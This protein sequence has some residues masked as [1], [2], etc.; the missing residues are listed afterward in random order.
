MGDRGI[1]HVKR[2]KVTAAGEWFSKYLIFDLWAS[3]VCFL[4]SFAH[5]PLSVLKRPALWARRRRPKGNSCQRRGSKKNMKSW[6]TL[7]KN[8]PFLFS[9][10]PAE[11]QQVKWAQ[12]KPCSW[13]PLTLGEFSTTLNQA[14][15]RCY[16]MPKPS[17]PR[18]QVATLSLCSVWSPRYS[19]GMGWSADH[20]ADGGRRERQHSH[21]LG[22]C[23]FL[24]KPGLLSLLRHATTVVQ[25]SL[26]GRWETLCY[27]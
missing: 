18:F 10:P 11:T 16:L 8:Q 27:I 23:E 24:P 14:F 7:G 6:E 12:E 4:S 5:S 25:L 21:P 3:E 2:R 22:K 19:R 13:Q 26:P 9:P 20:G 1:E 17:W 15:R